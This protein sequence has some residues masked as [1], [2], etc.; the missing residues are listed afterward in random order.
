MKYC[1][2]S[3]LSSVIRKNLHLSFYG[4]V[5]RFMLTTAHDPLNRFSFFPRSVWWV[6]LTWTITASCQVCIFSAV[7]TS[8]FLQ[9]LGNDSTDFAHFQYEAAHNF[10][11]LLGKIWIL[12]FGIYLLKLAHTQ[13]DGMTFFADTSSRTLGK[14]LA[15]IVCLARDAKCY[16]KILFNL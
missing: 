4:R 8:L 13:T 12:Q 9:Y 14:C 7:E 10:D 3:N 16:I 11:Y 6:S 1:E 5:A 2:N 15:T